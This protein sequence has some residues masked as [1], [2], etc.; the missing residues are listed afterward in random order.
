M[1]TQQ[2]DLISEKPTQRRK[3]LYR[4]RRQRMIGGVCGGTAEYVG[5]DP[6]LLRIACILLA[7]VGGWGIVAYIIGLIIIP[8]STEDDQLDTDTV[9]SQGKTGMIWGIL[10]IIAGL[11]FL[12]NNYG[13][14]PWS[15]WNFWH[16]SWRFFWP[17][18][19][20]F[21]GLVLLLTRSPRNEGIE[22]N[23][24]RTEPAQSRK[25]QRSRK[26]RM[27]GGVCGGIAGYF[28]LDPTLVR[29]LW[30]FGTILSRGLGILAYIILLIVLQN[31][32]LVNK[33][34]E[35]NSEV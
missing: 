15:M 1:N 27:I 18:V 19:L 12:L 2:D 7:L 34:I 29:L 6:A 20:I 9:S 28:R 32:E 17:F 25:L 21:I 22:E 5:V 24:T 31:E 33:S 30:A 4:S 8:E 35:S 16:I 26:D 10:F 23:G 13:W 3:R 11:I 14:L